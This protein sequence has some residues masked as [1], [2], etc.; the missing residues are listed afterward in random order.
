MQLAVGEILHALLEF[1]GLIELLGRSVG[2]EQLHVDGG[3]KGCDLLLVIGKLRQLGVEIGDGEVEFRLVD[4]QGAD[5][6]DDG[7]IGI[8]RGLERNK[9]AN[10]RTASLLVLNMKYPSQLHCRFQ[11][12]LNPAQNSHQHRIVAFLYPPNP[13]TSF[14]PLLSVTQPRVQNSFR[15]F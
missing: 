7:V 2:G 11:H 5:L 14:D 3:G 12:P 8:G 4:F 1:V 15:A 9:V 6:G 13:L 10:A